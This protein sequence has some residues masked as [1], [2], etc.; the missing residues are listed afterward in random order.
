VT[1]DKRFFAL[2][3]SKALIPYLRNTGKDFPTVYRHIGVYGYTLEALSAY[4]ALEQSELEKTEGLEQLR[5]L[6]NGMPIQV[7]PVDYRGRTHASIDTL[8]DLAVAERLI[9]QEGE[10][11]PLR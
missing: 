5:A 9:A 11:V 6:E 10:L 7:V 2:Y 8:E 3:F 1:V 4:A